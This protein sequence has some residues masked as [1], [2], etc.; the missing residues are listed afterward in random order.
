MPSSEH[1]GGPAAV[2]V[3]DND[4]FAAR[5]L[6]A[7][8]SHDPRHFHVMWWSSSAPEAIQRCLHARELPQVLVCDIALSGMTGMDVCATIRKAGSR[9]GVVLVTAYDPKEYV[10]DAVSVGAQAVL[11]KDEAMHGL[12]EAVQ[13]AAAGRGVCGCPDVSA[14]AGPGRNEGGPRVVPRL[15]ERE[16]AVMRFFAKG[17]K[18]DDIAERLDLSRNTV[19]AYSH[20]ALRKLHA[21]NREEAMEKCGRYDLFK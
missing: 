13:K 15:S 16:R 8:L 12:M 18:A 10:A 14:V 4:P 11:G 9:I 6:A 5:A 21:E 7:V 19:M 1:A 20:R 3:L 2:A 17:M